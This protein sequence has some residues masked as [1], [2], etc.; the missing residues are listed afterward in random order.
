[1]TIFLD[2]IIILFVLIGIIAIVYSYKPLFVK[3]RKNNK[4]TLSNQDSIAE[5]LTKIHDADTEQDKAKAFIIL[6]QLS[7]VLVHTIINQGNNYD[8]KKQTICFCES[9]TPQVIIEINSL[10]GKYE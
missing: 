6:M 9:L 10:E 7:Y 4:S 5:A 2:A 1:M 8:D 3:I